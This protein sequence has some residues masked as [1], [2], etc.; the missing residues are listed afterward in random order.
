MPSNKETK[1]ETKDKPHS[2]EQHPKK[3]ITPAI[4]KAAIKGAS[5]DKPKK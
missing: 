2:Y 4:G 3:D 1:P 5:K